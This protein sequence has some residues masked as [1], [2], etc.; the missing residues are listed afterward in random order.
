MKHLLICENCKEEFTATTYEL[1]TGRKYCSRECSQKA[2]DK[3]R[4]IVCDFCGEEKRV[5]PVYAERGAKFCSFGCRNA[6]M[7]V[8]KICEVCMTPYT[9]P[10]RRSE[11]KYCSQEC[12]HQAQKDQVEI[13][14]L[15][16]GDKRSVQKAH[17]DRTYCNLNCMY[18]H[19]RRFR[20]TKICEG[21]GIPFDVV[22]SRGEEAHYCSQSCSASVNIQTGKS[23]AIGNPKYFFRPDL[24]ITLRS[25]WEANYARIL[26]E[27]EIFWDYEVVR[28]KLSNG[29][30]YIPDF[31]L[32]ENHF[33]EIKGW[34]TDISR[35][36]V[37]L[38]RIEYPKIKLDVITGEEYK[39]LVRGWKDK[40]INWE[41]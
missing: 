1:N 31:M 25:T 35:E 22:P 3:K 5:S 8:E 2:R 4:T 10:G 13:T 30:V 32:S 24:G 19:F 36:K 27:Q 17:K 6:S 16:C 26:N 34:W 7:Q 29:T 12:S 21:C 11:S 28:F 15:N 9:V 41:N 23:G 38:F 40:I 18:E 33:V 20:V 37:H 39:V 14:C